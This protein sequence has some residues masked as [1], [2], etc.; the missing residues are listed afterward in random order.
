MK[1]Y[2]IQTEVQRQTTD[3]YM[4]KVYENDEA[5]FLKDLEPS[6][7]VIAKGESLMDAILKFEDLASK[8]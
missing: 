2:I 1:Y 3:F 5:K 6:A 8:E 7:K 4:V